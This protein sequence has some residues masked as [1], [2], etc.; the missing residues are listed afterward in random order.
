MSEA[1]GFIVERITA[2]LSGQAEDVLG[3]SNELVEF[4]S[5]ME[6]FQPLIEIILSPQE[7]KIKR[8]SVLLLARLLAKLGPEELDENEE[9]W[10]QIFQ[11]LFSET[12]TS[13]VRSDFMSNIIKIFHCQAMFPIAAPFI[14]QATE[15]KAPQINVDTAL[16]LIPIFVNLTGEVAG[17][18]EQIMAIV[19]K[20]LAL[21]NTLS[22]IHALQA[23]IKFCNIHDTENIGQFYELLNPEGFLALSDADY[24]EYSKLLIGIAEEEAE[25]FDPTTI[26]EVLLQIISNGEI[27]NQ[28]R[29]STFNVVL[30]FFDNYDALI[31]ED[32]IPVA[33]FQATVSLAESLFNEEDALD[34][35]PSDLLEIATCFAQKDELLQKFVES[36]SEL[37]ESALGCFC[38]SEFINKSAEDGIIFYEQNMEE[39]IQL[40]LGFLQTDCLSVRESAARCIALFETSCPS[41]M[42]KYAETINTTIFQVFSENVSV[43]MLTALHEVLSKT[44]NT[45]CI[46]DEALSGLTELISQSQSDSTILCVIADLVAGSSTKAAENF[47]DLFGLVKSI[48]AEEGN[49]L[50]SDAVFLLSRL[51]Y[52][53]KEQFEPNVDEISQFL[54]QGFDSEDP[55]ISKNFINAYSYIAQNFPERCEETANDVVA[56]LAQLSPSESAE[57]EIIIEPS[58]IALRVGT[59][60]ASTF[61]N[62]FPPNADQFLEALRMKKNIHG[63][64]GSTFFVRALESFDDVEF[65]A[66]LI[67][68]IAPI[69]IDIIENGS[70]QASGQAFTAATDLFGMLGMVESGEELQQKFVECGTKAFTFELQCIKKSKPIFYEELHAPAK[71]LLSSTIKCGLIPQIIENAENFIQFCESTESVQ[72]KGTYALILAETAPVMGAEYPQQIAEYVF[73]TAASIIGSENENYAAYSCIEKLAVIGSPVLQPALPELYPNLIQKLTELNPQRDGDDEDA[74][75]V[76]DNCLSAVCSILRSFPDIDQFE[77]YSSLLLSCMPPCFDCDENTNVLTFFEE[78]K[79]NPLAEGKIQEFAVVLIRLFSEDIDS[80]RAQ[81]IDDEQIGRFIGYLKETAAAIQL[82]PLIA[83]ITGGADTEKAANVAAALAAEQE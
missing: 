8:E 30:S 19:Q 4:C 72:L 83:Q 7:E 44:G 21:T 56:K 18:G 43:E 54:I 9:I 12:T 38:V 5:T 53:C 20:G 67:T 57:Q 42:K 52:K 1:S 36:F 10:G 35:A 16:Q 59:M 32:E 39:I 13:V 27:S 15:E 41:T 82:E 24:N 58:D 25:G 63:A 81:L 14:A 37:T 46:F 49:P 55:S 74:K 17:I 69:I 50:V 73:Q 78:M 77:N 51:C 75:L 11:I 60:L 76:L 26:M 65:L 48:L 40:L 70:L 62:S 45:D 33:A 2:I 3:L 66:P 64:I 47:D 6:A 80:L 61:P 68:E 23:A 28:K 31:E 34:M 71:D 29:K 79:A 22:Y